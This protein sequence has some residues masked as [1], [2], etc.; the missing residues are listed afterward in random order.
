[1]SDTKEIKFKDDLLALRGKLDADKQVDKD[2]GVVTLPAG[3]FFK[4]APEAVTEEVYATTRNY[5]DLYAQ[6][7]TLMA[8]ETAVELFKGNKDLKNVSLHAPIWGKDTLSRNFNR[9]GEYRNLKNKDEVEMIK[10]V[11]GMDA[12]KWSRVSTR[13]QSEE[14]SI[15]KHLRALATDAGL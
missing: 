7:A 13:T 9:E 5:E 2:T 10:Y 15:K 3:T 4:H 11:G 1:M 12:R 6:S 8:A 14:D